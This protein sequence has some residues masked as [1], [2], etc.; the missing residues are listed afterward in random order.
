M[1]RNK[2]ELMQYVF[3]DVQKYEGFR[4]FAKA[5][6]L[7]RL[8]ITKRP[9][10][11]LHPNPDDEFSMPAIGPHFGIINEY[12]AKFTA[13]G[14]SNDEKLQEPLYIEK[15]TRDGYMILNGHH[16]W[17]AAML[18]GINA[19]PVKIVNL[20]HEEDHR[21]MMEKSQNDKRVT[22]D[23][24]EVLCT[25]EAH[26]RAEQEPHLLIGSFEKRYK[27]RLRWGAPTLIQE[28]QREGFDVWIYTNNFY[29]VEYLQSFFHAYKVQVDGIIN[30]VGRRKS[31]KAEAVYREMVA[32]KYHEVYNVDNDGVL[33]IQPGTR[34][35]ESYDLEV[36]DREWANKVMDTIKSISNKP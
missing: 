36:S 31:K 2:T 24:D 10:R 14:S 16:R 33:S 35:F 27:E 34:E 25:T 7:E 12:C 6:I 22:F 19:L 11:L 30:G 9:P 26:P 17:A 8:L 20:T 13:V 1:V 18:M 28:L 32:K 15:M 21:K 3:D 5:S 23:F 4:H 29:S